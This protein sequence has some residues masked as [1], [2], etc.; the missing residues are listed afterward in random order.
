MFGLFKYTEKKCARDIIKIINKHRP[1]LNPF[2]DEAN[3]QVNYADGHVFLGNIFNQAKN[4][5]SSE[6]MYFLEKFMQT[7]LNEDEI[8]YEASAD[9]L[10]PR[11][12]T[13]HEV[14][15][16]RYYLSPDKRKEFESI[17]Q[18]LTDNFVL[19]L[20]LDDE[21]AVQIVNKSILE[22]LDLSFA[23][24]MAIAK[25][26][27]F[28]LGDNP[29]EAVSDGIYVSRFSDDHDAARILF[30]DEIRQ[31]EVKGLPVVFV[32]TAST[33]LVCGSQDIETLASLQPLLEKAGEGR[34]PL[35]WYPLILTEQGW[36]DWT[37]EET[38]EY[39]PV[40]N[41]ITLE[42]LDQYKTQ[43]DA[44]DKYNEENNI[45]IFVANYQVFEKES[46]AAY[47]SLA[48]WTETVHTW[49][50]VTKSIMFVKI[51]DEE[52]EAIGDVP[53]AKVLKEFGDY[54]KPM[55]TVPERYEVKEFPPLEKITQLITTAANK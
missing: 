33:M 6:R 23:E 52:A 49:L 3:R 26:N 2:Y 39:A 40:R 24:A 25:K 43:K 9:N 35:S 17:H 37:P 45:D 54:M 27:L 47:D 4:L 31:L 36:R 10:V 30:E 29:F 46:S 21:Q 38:E 22:D 53:F 28:T 44:L 51:V 8:S 14:A 41:L 18:E 34:R 15:M 19:E 13:R 5:S 50:P 32:A 16:R 7:G 1:E 55:G 11:L 42:T 20:G 48:S 12:K